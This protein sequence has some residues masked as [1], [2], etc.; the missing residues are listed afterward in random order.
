[1][2]I[3]HIVWSIVVGFVVGLL[4]RAL[5]PGADHMGFFATS[6]LGILG[7]LVGGFVGSLVSRP[8]EGA[9]FHPAGLV[10]SVIGA[11]ILLFIWRHA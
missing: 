4:A 10:L 7:S 2:G 1:M 6:L 11:M 5:M 8:K 3:T 9:V